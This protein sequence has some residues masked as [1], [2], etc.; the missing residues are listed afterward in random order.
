[1]VLKSFIETATAIS[2]LAT[3]TTTDVIKRAKAALG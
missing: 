2:I 3:L 1:M